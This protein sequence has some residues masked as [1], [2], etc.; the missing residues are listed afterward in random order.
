MAMVMV[1]PIV[2]VPFIVE[3][4]SIIESRADPNDWSSIV[5]VISIIISCFNFDANAYLRDLFWGSGFLAVT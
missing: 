1:I 4:N 3:P 5:V 2:V